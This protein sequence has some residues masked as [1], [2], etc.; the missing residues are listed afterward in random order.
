MKSIYTF[1]SYEY[2]EY[3]GCK[4]VMLNIDQK[5]MKECRDG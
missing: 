1:K 4:G 5:G 3:C 2:L